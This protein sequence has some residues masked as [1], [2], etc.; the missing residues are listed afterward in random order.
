MTDTEVPVSEDQQDEI[1]PLD[2]KVDV[3]S[4]SACQRHVAV[5][6]DR[7]DVDRYFDDEIG[8]LMEEANVPG[9]R[10]GRAPRKLVAS[11]FKGE[12]AEKVKGSLLM[13]SMTQVTE[14]QDFAAIS[15]PEFDFDAV[16]IPEEG[17]LTFEFN[18]EVRPEFDMPKWKGLK[19]DKPTKEY[20]KKDIDEQ[21]VRLLER[22]A[23]EEPVD[24]PADDNDLVA[25][26]IKFKQD[27][28]EIAFLKDTA[29]RVREQLSF[30]D[31]TL[32]EF[33]KLVNGAKAGETK[34]SK[35][36][37][38]AQAE[39]EEL[40]GKEV[41]VEMEVLDVKRLVPPEM[42]PE[43]IKNLGS[44]ENEG[45][46][47][48]AVQQELERQLTYHQNRSV[49]EQITSMLTE[50]A[51]W[52]LPPDLLRRQASREL[53]R[54]VMELRSSGFSDDQIRAH[55]NQLKQNSEESTATALKEH[56]ILERIAEDEDF[57]ASDADYEREILMMAM[58]SGESPRAVRARIDKQGLMDALR[59]QIVENM[60]IDR[61]KEEAKFNEVKFEPS[62]E[63]VSA[64]DFAIGGSVDASI[65]DAKHGG[66]ES[67]L[68]QPVD[69]T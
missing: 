26:N 62:K 23:V 43:L 16:T 67:E 11:H 60:V 49:R 6:V 24:G 69:R 33:G 66:D 45:E 5:T 38:S 21:L 8:K 7:A 48:D 40:R 13:D 25:L 57:E 36:K 12:L 32:D 35:L 56:F 39:N 18:I 22:H 28:K 2:L 50:S 51:D 37:I 20:G 3:K 1:Q 58:Q 46:L 63:T 47:R 19:I 54:A 53:Q 68:K 34:T 9:F 55:V 4:P 52:E 14:D 30:S 10:P 15:E 61:I 29:V 27:G 44:F 42:T 65:P 41:D 31:G 59:N 17:P 64:V